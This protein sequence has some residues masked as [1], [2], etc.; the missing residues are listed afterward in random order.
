M[1]ELNNQLQNLNL[2][3]CEE[4]GLEN[5]SLPNTCCN[6]RCKSCK[7][8]DN[9]TSICCICNKIQCGDC[10]ETIVFKC[11]KCD[12]Y[13]CRYCTN[14]TESEDLMFGRFICCGPCQK[15][16]QNCGNLISPYLNY[17]GCSDVEMRY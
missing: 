16:C 2:N 10:I 12:Y 9:F 1:N 4:C 11:D 15:F 6:R 14:F 5:N 7:L 17:C 3:S 13:F 8:K